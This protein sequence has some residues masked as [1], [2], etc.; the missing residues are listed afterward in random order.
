MAD[1]DIEDH[2]DSNAE[3]DSE[4]N[5]HVALEISENKKREKILTLN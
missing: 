4:S 5:G 2:L 1:S 3:S